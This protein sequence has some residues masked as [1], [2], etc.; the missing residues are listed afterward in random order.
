MNLLDVVREVRR[1]LEENGRL[2]LRLLRRQF[3][4][5][6][7]VLE[8]VIGE[9]VDVQRVARREENALAWS[10]PTPPVGIPPQARDP[11]TYTPKR[12]VDKS[13]EQF[14]TLQEI[15]A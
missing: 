4:L 10:A 15:G 2:S 7:D 1:H 8:E 11:L 5:D 13:G 3:E 9:L 6:D 12:L 14:R